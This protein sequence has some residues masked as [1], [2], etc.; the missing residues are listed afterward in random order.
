MDRSEVPVHIGGAG[1]KLAV[2]VA[3]MHAAAPEKRKFITLSRAR[4]WLTGARWYVWLHLLRSSVYAVSQEG[5]S[6]N[7]ELCYS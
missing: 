5:Q 1:R 7:F 3:G 6:V 2:R 4:G